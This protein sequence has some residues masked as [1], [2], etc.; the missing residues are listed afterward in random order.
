MHGSET[1]QISTIVR[2]C[3][4]SFT[5]TESLP[6]DMRGFV[7]V[8][9]LAGLEAAGSLTMEL[10]QSA[11]NV[12]W[13]PVIPSYYQAEGMAGPAAGTSGLKVTATTT[14]GH[15]LLSLSLYHQGRENS[16]NGGVARFLRVKLTGVPTFILATLGQASWHPVDQPYYAVAESKGSF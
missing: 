3:Y 14:Q 9:F 1:H 7:S 8:Q 13:S 15:K 5:A 6:V 4:L 11:D 10:E 16:I 12:T 2:Q